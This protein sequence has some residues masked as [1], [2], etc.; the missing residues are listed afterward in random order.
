MKMDFSRVMELLAKRYGDGEAIVNVER[1]RRYSFKAYHLLTNRIANMMR[2]ALGLK[3]DDVAIAM[4][5]NDNLTLLH[6]PTIF[7]QEAAI[8]FTNFRDSFA[9]HMWQV[10]FIKP[11]VVFVENR[12]LET[13]YQALRERNCTIVAMDPLEPQERLPGVLS[14][15]ELLETAEDTNPGIELDIHNHMAV[16]RFTGGTT[17]NG[18]CAQYCIDHFM[19]TR[20]AANACRDFDAGTDS[21][22]LLFTPISHGGLLQF[23]PTFLAGG[24][25][26]T[27]NMPDL[28]QWAEVVEKESITHA[29]L[30]P[31][32]L[33]RLADGRSS[34]RHNLS[35]LQLIIYG[36]APMAPARLTQLIEQFGPIFMQ[37]YGSTET[38]Q[39]VTVL[40][41]ADHVIHSDSAR[42]RLASAGR[43]VPGT[44]LYIADDEGRPVPPNSV[45]EIRLRSRATIS[46]Y[47]NNPEATAKEFENGFWLS[48]DLGYL[49]DDGYVFIV[50]RKKDMIITGGFN[51]YAVEVEAALTEHQAVSAAAVV[52][53]PHADWGEAVHAEVTLRPGATLTAE[54]LID[55]AKK[56]L[57][58]K[59]PKTVSI[60]SEL[61]VS[62]VGK[63]LRRKVREKYWV[64]KTRAIG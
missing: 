5:D 41:K 24:A 60:V 39:F 57:S 26:Y 34:E 1:D 59:A 36:A 7:K 28:E 47:Y 48:G 51:V 30:V 29:F 3:K 42:A 15:W 64:G 61:P 10:D 16:F 54:E 37:A 46:G 4:V 22:L 18:K 23:W 33:Y 52:G 49:D 43:I 31:T 55:F 58:Y 17:G 6:F 2:G 62:A 14:F 45:G 35:S 25:T 11:R 38:I 27:L 20:D 21:K 50:D 12:L 13:H 8:A 53:I 19:G 44:E 63:V 9:E 56:R 40:E 32:L